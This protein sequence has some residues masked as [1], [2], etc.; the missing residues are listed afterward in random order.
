MVCRGKG[1]PQISVSG[2]RSAPLGQTTVPCSTLTCLKRVSSALSGSKIGPTIRLEMFRSMTEPSV[3]VSCNLLSWRGIACRILRSDMMSADSIPEGRLV[4]AVARPLKGS[5]PAAVLP[6]EG[7]PITRSRPMRGGAVRL[8]RS[9]VYSI[10]LM[11]G[12]R[13]NSHENAAAHGH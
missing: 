6:G 13:H 10:R 5:N 1:P 2:H 8:G 11:P 4:L 7:P 9:P 3:S 12:T